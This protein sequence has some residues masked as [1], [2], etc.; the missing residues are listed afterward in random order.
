MA[1]NFSITDALASAIMVTGHFKSLLD[2][3]TLKLYSGTMPA[4]ANS[5]LSGN[6]MLCQ[7]FK[8]ND[9][10]TPLTFNSTAPAGVI[11]KNSTES[12]AGTVANTG[13]ATFYRWEMAGDTGAAATTE[14]RLQGTVSTAGG[15]LDLTSTALTAAAIQPI[16][17]FSV[18]LPTY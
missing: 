17:A 11:G 12:W 16:N 18:S 1:H 10:S 6:T 9:G 13:T 14:Y 2:G 15:D 4:T 5:A 8:D 7:I 3:G